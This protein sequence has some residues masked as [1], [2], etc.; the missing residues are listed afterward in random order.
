ML[1]LACGFSGGT[2]QAL[3][4]TPDDSHAHELLLLHGVGLVEDDTDFFV[5]IAKRRDGPL[6]FVGDVQFVRIEEEDDH[7]WK[8]GGLTNEM[9]SDRHPYIYK[10]VPASVAR[11]R[12]LRKPVDDLDKVVGSADALLFARENAGRVNKRDALQNGA[13]ALRALQALQKGGAKLLQAAEGLVLL[14]C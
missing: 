6:K 5:V 9:R 3:D 8:G 7:V 10:A 13:G 4:G 11:T 1:D 12:F 14:H 2:R